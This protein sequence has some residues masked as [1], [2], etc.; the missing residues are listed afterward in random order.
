MSMHSR[1]T[2]SLQTWR[3]GTS[4]EMVLPDPGSATP[5]PR[6][7]TLSDSQLKSICSPCFKLFYQA[8][9]SNKCLFVLSFPCLPLT[10]PF[11]HCAA[12][13]T[14]HWGPVNLICGWNST[15]QFWLLSLREMWGTQN[16][17]WCVRTISWNCLAENSHSRSTCPSTPSGF[18][19]AW[20]LRGDWSG[21]SGFLP[22]RHS[23]MPLFAVYTEV[24][25]RQRLASPEAL[26]GHT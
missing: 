10:L 6:S 20:W 25:L 26:L 24:T 5:T 13:V 9:W 12:K 17:W 21:W 2:V 18:S 22:S 14:E 11:P 8:W 7:P 3:A 16:Q 19:T 1:S 23:Q 15:N 4:L